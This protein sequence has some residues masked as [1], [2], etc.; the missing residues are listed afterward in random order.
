MSMEIYGGYSQYQTDGAQMRKA[1]Q[2]KAKETEKDRNNE[3][4]SDQA[5]ALR[6]E[7][8]SSEKSGEKPDGLY[9]LGRDKDGR[10]KVFFDDPKKS[11]EKCTANT[12][13]VDGQ[14]RKLKEEKQQLEQQIRSA[15]GDD[16]KTRE[17]EK[18][19]AQVEK[20]LSRKDN[21]TYRRQN[22]SFSG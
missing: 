3:K 16:R 18:K 21:D 2:E 14:V 7:Y 12:D 8:I 13:R 22:T 5:S 1:E 11:E 20:E 15:V 4:A 19:L 10:K 9:R 6:D 17:L